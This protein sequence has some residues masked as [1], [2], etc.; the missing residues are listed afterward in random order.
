MSE[1]KT[2]TTENKQVKNETLVYIGPTIVG[3]VTQNT[4]F[5]NGLSN[6]LQSLIEK[7]PAINNLVVPISRYTTAASSINKKEGA[8][9][10]FYKKV[11]QYR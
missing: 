5:N 4:F 2:K 3:V 6:E 11:L 9:Y 8:M 10:E 1:R 7:N